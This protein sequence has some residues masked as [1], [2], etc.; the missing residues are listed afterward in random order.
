MKTLIVLAI[1]GIGLWLLTSNNSSPSNYSYS[2]YTSDDESE[3]STLDSSDAL[4]DHWAEI[5]E[6]LDGT[7]TV[8]ACSDNSGN[9][10]GLDAD[11]DQGQIETIYPPNGGYVGIYSADVDSDGD[12]SGSDDGDNEDYWRFKVNQSDI[13]DALQSWADSNDINLE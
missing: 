1:L 6:Y 7:Y 2:G 4:S 3:E 11:I 13:E 8:E 12:A 5:A 9:C 10:Y